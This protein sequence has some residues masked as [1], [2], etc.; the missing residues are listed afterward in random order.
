[1][2]H[3][4]FWMSMLSHASPLLVVAVGW[5]RHGWLWACALASFISD[6]LMLAF[7]NMEQADG[8]V[9]NLFVAIEFILFSAYYRR[10]LRLPSIKLLSTLF[11]VPYILHTVWQDP[12]MNINFAGAAWLHILYVLYALAGFR[13]ILTSMSDASLQTSAVFWTSC[14]LLLQAAAASLYFL[15]YNE[16]AALAKLDPPRWYSWKIFFL[17]MNILKSLLLTAAVRAEKRPSWM[18]YA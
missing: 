4:A 17:T 5:R 16:L 13:R 18:I 6:S 2:E 10:V 12:V 7:Q 14:T 9:A 3:V 15:Y 1:M 11:L 8:W